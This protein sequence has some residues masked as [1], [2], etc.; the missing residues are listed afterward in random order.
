[1]GCDFYVRVYLEIEHLH[2]ISYYELPIIRGYYPELVCGICDSDDDEND[3]YYN[4]NE[5]DT[6]YEHMKKVCLTPRKP[7]VIYKENTFTTPAL[8][9]KYLPNILTKRN[10]KNTSKYARY[11]DTGMFTS[12]EQ[13]IQVVKKE[14]RYECTF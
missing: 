13:I 9:M 14:D 8:E 7:L 2:G 12:I 4:S 5:Y 10:N 1:M 3:Y 11:K 6:L